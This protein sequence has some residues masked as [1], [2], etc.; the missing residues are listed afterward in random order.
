M[1]FAEL[2]SKVTLW[3]TINEPVV[4]A[5][6]GWG[7]GIF[8]PGKKDLPLAGQVLCNLLRAHVHVYKELKSLPNGDSCK[9]G[10]VKV[11][12]QPERACLLDLNMGLRARC[13]K[14]V[15]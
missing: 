1:V 11:L 15:R 4:F 5:F 13:D 10:I 14:D 3:C 9:I 8:P 12:R 2:S 6:N 7:A